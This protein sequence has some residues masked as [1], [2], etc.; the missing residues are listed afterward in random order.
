MGVQNYDFWCTPIDKKLDI[1]W[2]DYNYKEFLI[3]T[4][5]DA[6]DLRLRIAM[7]NEYSNIFYI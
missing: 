6:I 3:S 1:A 4:L 7:C 2:K 5:C